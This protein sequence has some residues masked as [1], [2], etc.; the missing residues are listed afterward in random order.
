MAKKN[1]FK[2]KLNDKNTAN[3]RETKTKVGYSSTQKKTIFLL[4]D[5]SQLN[6]L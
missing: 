6:N 1:K 5:E 2:T 4:R 3:R